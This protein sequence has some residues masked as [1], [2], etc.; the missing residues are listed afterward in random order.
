MT[1]RGRLL[2]RRRG[3][4]WRLARTWRNRAGRSIRRQLR[5]DLPVVSGPPSAL[6]ADPAYQA[7][8]RDIAV[9]LRGEL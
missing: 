4:D 7:I 6:W 2:V 8:M 1:R 5:A 3:S 9:N